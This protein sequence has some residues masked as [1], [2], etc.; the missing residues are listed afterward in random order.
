MLVELLDRCQRLRLCTRA[1]PFEDGRCALERMPRDARD[2]R[3]CAAGFRQSGNCR[4]AEVVKGHTLDVGRLG[5]LVPA[6]PEPIGRPG[7]A[8]RVRE[9]ECRAAGSRLKRS[10]KFDRAWDC[11]ERARLRLPERNFSAVERGPGETEQVALSLP[12]IE[13]KTDRP[14]AVFLTTQAEID[15]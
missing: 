6:R 12:G 3:H 5:G 13:C 9:D 4:P 10:A 8:A 1:I 14:R 7:L 2:L 15:K 11:D